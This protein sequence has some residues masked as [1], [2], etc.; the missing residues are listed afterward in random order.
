MEL[1]RETF[2]EVATIIGEVLQDPDLAILPTEV[3]RAVLRIRNAAEAF[4]PESPHD[5]RFALTGAGM[6]LQ[7]LARQGP[8]QRDPVDSLLR[9]VR[10]VA[11]GDVLYFDRSEARQM[12][13]AAGVPSEEREQRLA[14]CESFDRSFFNALHRVL[15]RPESFTEVVE[16]MKG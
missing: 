5:M 15:T 13:E 11:D 3:S 7:V 16:G 10:E 8:S 14:R 9:G 4:E 2:G 1:P 6:V 12:M